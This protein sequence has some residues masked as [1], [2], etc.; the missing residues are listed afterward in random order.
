MKK[1]KKK[2]EA[3][4]ITS[5]NSFYDKLDNSHNHSGTDHFLPLKDATTKVCLLDL[6]HGNFL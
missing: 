1:K 4:E 3:H 5:F 6:V 2:I